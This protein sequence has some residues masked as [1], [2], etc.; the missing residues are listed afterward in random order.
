MKWN[1]H[2]GMNLLVRHFIAEPVKLEAQCTKLDR[3]KTLAQYHI[4]KWNPDVKEN[5]RYLKRDKTFI[6]IG[7]RVSIS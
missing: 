4:M 2:S 6:H 5:T 1:A 7:G 3:C